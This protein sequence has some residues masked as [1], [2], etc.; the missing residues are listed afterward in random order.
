MIQLPASALNR[1]MK[2]NGSVAML[3]SLEIPPDHKEQSSDQLEGDAVHDVAVM[4]FNGQISDPL[5]MVDRKVVNGIYITPEMTDYIDPFCMEIKSRQREGQEF[6]I[7]TAMDFNISPETRILC[8]PDVVT[9]D[10]VAGILSIDDLKYGFRIVE[11]FDNWTLIAYAMSWIINKQIVPVQILL[12]IHQPRPHHENGKRRTLVLTYAELC[13]LYQQM[14]DRLAVL[15]D[16]LHTGTHC[17]HCPALVPCRAARNAMMNAIDVSSTVFHDKYS[18]N[19]LGTELMIAERAAKALKDRIDAMKELMMFRIGEQGEINQEWAIERE[20]GNRKY[21][22]HATPELIKT[23]TGIDIAK[24]GMLTPAQAI[25]KSVPESVI[26]A[27]TT[28]PLLTPKLV[29]KSASKRA[30]ALFGKPSN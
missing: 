14:V 30:E 13:Q 10:P 1:V 27:F 29:H 6:W 24:P 8:R 23:I 4:V 18:T 25:K 26:N 9:Y 7:E 3:Q 12:T 17:Y 28:R 11:P 22:P 20:L 19:D 5:E 15:S 21:L 16:E 2:C